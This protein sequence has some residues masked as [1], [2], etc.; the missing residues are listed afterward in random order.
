MLNKTHGHNLSPCH[1]V[2]GVKTLLR[3]KAVVF[4]IENEI[5]QANSTQVLTCPTTAQ[6]LG[7]SQ[8]TSTEG[9]LPDSGRGRS[10][11]EKSSHSSFRARVEK[12]PSSLPGL[13]SDSKGA[14]NP[15]GRRV[16]VWDSS[17]RVCMPRTS[18]DKNKT[19]KTCMVRCFIPHS[20]SHSL[21]A[22]C[23][24]PQDGG[25]RKCHLRRT[26]RRSKRSQRKSSDLKESFGR[27]RRTSQTPGSCSSPDTAQ[28]SW[29]A[30]EPEIWGSLEGFVTP[31]LMANPRKR[32]PL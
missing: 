11:R 28:R 32:L 5:N 20:Q 12:L 9:T 2:T 15:R 8:V 21:Q 30:V 27:S 14:A 26:R 24:W 4:P 25:E 19:L 17:R 7:T 22:F 10:F 23:V 1:E 6:S 13:C 16:R 31:L 18:R 29:P 3:V